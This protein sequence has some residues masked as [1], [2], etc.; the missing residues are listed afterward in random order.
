M[1]KVSLFFCI[2]AVLCFVMSSTVFCANKYDCASIN[3][4]SYALIDADSGNLICGRNESVRMG[5]AST[6]KIMTAIVAIENCP[7][8][9]TVTVS[10]E[11]E[12]VEGS[13]IYLK[14]GEEM[15]LRELLYA[16]LLESAN[17]AAVAISVSVCGSVDDFVDL[18]NEKAQQLC[19]CNTHFTNPHGLYDEQHYT[20]SYDMCKLLAYCMSNP[21]F[22]KIT[23]TKKTALHGSDSTYSRLLINHNK[24]LK[25]DGITGGKTG[26]TKKTGRCLVTCYEKDGVRLIACTLNDPDDWTDHRQLFAY[27]YKLYKFT[28]FE[29]AGELP[30]YAHVCGGETDYVKLMLADDL[31]ATVRDGVS[32]QRVLN[33][34]RFYYA[35][36][37]NG[38]IMGQLC[39]YE[40]DR[41]I[42]SA[43]IIAIGN[44]KKLGVKKSILEKIFG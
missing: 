11:A 20:T 25:E 29:R 23:A 15:T 31:C 37:S 21:E 40:N 28:C 16:L 14:Q 36:V 2:F 19:L 32:Y 33:I 34:K 30:E 27:G 6:T 38:E 41:L 4:L 13:S 24:L 1:K 3:A 43:D 10:K 39:Y 9:C 7:L 22:A 8:D 44:V 26:F 17:D 12:G 18:M 5:M 42:C 35:P